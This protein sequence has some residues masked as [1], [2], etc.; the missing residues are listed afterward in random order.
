MSLKGKYALVT[1]SSRG[2]GRGIA[3][4]LAEQGARVA[5]HYYQ[6]ESAA[7]ATLEKVRALG[8]DG[9]VVQADVCHPDQ[10]KQ[11]FDRVKSEFGALDVFV[12]NARTEAPT[13]YQPTM[14]ITLDKWDTAVDSQAK[15][16][17]VG[18]REAAALMKQ[19]GR[20]IAITYAPGGRFGSWQPWVAMGAAK[21]AMEVLVRYFAVALA[22]RGITVNSVSPGWV[23]DSVLNSLPDAVQQAVRDWQQNGWTPMGRLGTP[24]DI[25]NAV[26]LLCSPEAAW[27]TGQ[28]IDVDGGAS[29]MNAHAPLEIQQSRPQQSRAA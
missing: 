28:L 15:A 19:G 11:I 18:A 26:S 22:H 24:A 16:F 6:N 29:L 13:F 1:G 9:F 3:L 20:I 23:D 7:K 5:I 8:S 4:K 21:A 14:E 27:I 12:S 25:G 17:L 2:I 10:V